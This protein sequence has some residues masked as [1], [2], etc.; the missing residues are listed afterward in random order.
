MHTFEL[1]LVLL[2]GAVLVVGIFRSLN[3]PP[4][5]GYL[6]VGAAVGPHAM[7]L[8]PDTG[9]ARYLAEFGVVFLM[10]TIGLEFSLP[11]L[12]SMKRIVFGLGAM[13]VLGCIAVVTMVGALAGLGWGPSFALGGTLAMSSTAIISKL[14][15][16]RLELDSKHGRETIG[17]LLFQDLAVV[18]LLILIPA[19]SKPTDEMLTTLALAA[20][21]AV[22]MLGLVL[23]LGQKVM[24]RW[25][26]EVARQRSAELFMLNVLFI[27]LGLAWL[28]ERAGLSLALGAF[29]AGMLISE[30][31][32][33]YHVEEDI[34]PFRDV[35]LGL[36]FVTV[37]MFLDVGRIILSL[38]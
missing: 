21:K 37:G 27:T 29:L 8:M 26:F 31:E 2:A 35:L 7:N 15:S 5:L 10:F 6:M 28:T 32:Y 13:Q 25:F 36:F 1:V 34:K 24:R 18:P 3:L 38:P 19:L 22:A 23:F 12:Y 4:V 14:L 30:T 17:V 20:A 11:R 33:R 9:G 16:D